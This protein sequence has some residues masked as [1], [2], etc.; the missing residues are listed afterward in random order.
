M[1]ELKRKAKAAGL[2]NLWITA[3]LKGIVEAKLASFGGSVEGGLGH[4][5]TNEEYVPIAAEMGRSVYASEV[6]NCSAPDTGNAE[7]LARFGS[8]GHCRRWLVD[9]L[10]GRTRSAFLMTERA[11]AS[12]DAT[13]ICT[14]LSAAGGASG[15]FEVTGAKWW[16]R[17]AAL[18]FPIRT[19]CF[20]L[21]APRSTR[22]LVVGRTY[23]QLRAEKSCS[24]LP[25][26]LSM[27]SLASWVPLASRA[28]PPPA[29]RWTLD[30]TS[31]YAYAS[32]NAATRNRAIAATASLSSR[33]AITA[34]A[35]SAHCTSSA[36][37][38]R[39]TAT[40]RW[41]WT[42]CEWGG[43]TF[44][45]RRPARASSR[46]RA[47]SDQ[48]RTVRRVHRRLLPPRWMSAIRVFFDH[49]R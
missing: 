7:I 27:L 19:P 4:G 5:F 1:E 11:V 12:S 21:L 31:A 48:V 46:R 49:A 15:E 37:M 44:S 18:P 23:R 34:C 26:S 3:E 36:L 41:R 40:R 2:W 38:T 9:L 8:E 32:T 17:C 30:V 47:G 14:R 22:V 20:S 13:N 24:P 33:F 39:P 35:S 6:F 43:K 42:P 16:S 29:A 25:V 28:N 45:G 10:S